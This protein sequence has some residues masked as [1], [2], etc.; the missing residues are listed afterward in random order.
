MLPSITKYWK[1]KEEYDRVHKVRMTAPAPQMSPMFNYSILFKS[2]ADRA[3]MSDSELRYFIQRNFQAIMNNIFNR[4]A[5]VQYLEAF[6]DIKFLDAFIDVIQYMQ[7]FDGDVIVRLNTLAYHYLTA[8][9]SIKKIEV[10]QRMYTIGSIINRTKLIGLKKFNLS[11][12]M[13]NVLLIARYSDFNLSV[14]IKRVNIILS[15][16][17]EI[18]EALDLSDQYECP[19]SSIDWLAKLI[20]ELY[21]ME[22]W[23]LVLPY[24]MLDVLPD[25]DDIN[26]GWVTEEVEAVDS[27]LNLAVLKILDEMIGD[28]TKLRGILVSYAEGYRVMNNRTKPRFSFQS[29]SEEYKRLNYIVKYLEV[30][31]NI[32]VP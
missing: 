10:A 18:F 2:I 28:S 15:I 24:F 20:L 32:Y 25:S 5:G 23:E 31:E 17:K 22:N 19:E 21:K 16:N 30:E 13:E 8:P 6:Q 7:F 1:D 26:A 27:A 3:N 9:E 11:T 14:C 12:N 4:E 29:I